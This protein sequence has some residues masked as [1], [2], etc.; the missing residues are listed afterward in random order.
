MVKTKAEENVKNLAKV[1]EVDDNLN[2]YVDEDGLI[3]LVFNPGYEGSLSPRGH[4]KVVETQWVAIPGTPHKL[5]AKM[6]I[7]RKK[8]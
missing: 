6:I 7:I 2:S 3:H 1:H 5:T 8:A 4:T